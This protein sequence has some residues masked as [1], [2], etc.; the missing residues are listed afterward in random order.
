MAVPM[1]NVWRLIGANANRATG[2]MRVTIVFHFVQINAQMVFVRRPM[3]VH[4]ILVTNLNLVPVYHSVK[5]VVLMENALPQMCANVM[6][7]S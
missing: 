5:M 6:R 7:V 3:F 1:A 2:K 4:A